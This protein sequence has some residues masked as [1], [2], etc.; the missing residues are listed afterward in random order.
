VE[1]RTA[2]WSR[3][4]PEDRRA[5]ILAASQR[6]FAH[7]SYDQIGMADVARE[8]GVSRALV[9]HYFGSKRELYLETLKVVAAQGPDQVR[10]DLELPVREMVAANADSWLD[11]VEA[12][13]N[14]TLAM[15]GGGAFAGDPE[16]EREL[17]DLRDALVDRMIANHFGGADIPPSARLAFRAYTGLWEVAVRDWLVGERATREEVRALLVESLLVIVREVI[18]RLAEFDK[19]QFTKRMVKG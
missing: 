12:N 2:R 10:T 8:A 16:S 4:P 3:R 9:N 18:P 5:D 6:V 7:A 15:S 11:F 19:P 17:S 1:R 13:P 14:T